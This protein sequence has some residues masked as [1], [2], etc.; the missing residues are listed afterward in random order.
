MSLDVEGKAPQD[1]S[2]EMEEN[3][4]YQRQL[5][6]F[7]R[8]STEKGIELLKIGET[9]AGLRHRRYFLDIGAGGGDLTV[10]ISQSFNETTI[11]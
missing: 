7:V 8:C 9:V 1:R 2:M 10:P 6:L 4:E 3:V 5:A 11:V